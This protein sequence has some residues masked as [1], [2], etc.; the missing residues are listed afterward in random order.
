MPTYRIMD[1]EGNIVDNTRDP[2]SA[3]DSEIISWYKTMLTISIMDIIMYESQRQGRIS[4][5]M[6]SAGEEGIAV[7]SATESVAV[8]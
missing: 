4:F 2:Q 7:G 1:A 3:P 6:V 8:V 5:Y